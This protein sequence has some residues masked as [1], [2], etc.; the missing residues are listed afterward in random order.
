MDRLNLLHNKWV[1]TNLGVFTINNIDGDY[2][3]HPIDYFNFI[4]IPFISLLRYKYSGSGYV[5]GKED[6]FMQ[7]ITAKKKGVKKKIKHLLI[8]SASENQEKLGT[9]I[10]QKNTIDS[11]C[12]TCSALSIYTNSISAVPGGRGYRP[13]IGGGSQFMIY[14]WYGINETVVRLNNYNGLIQQPHV[15]WLADDDIGTCSICGNRGIVFHSFFLYNDSNID[16]SKKNDLQLKDEH[17][18]IINN[19]VTDFY[20][21]F[22]IHQKYKNNSKFMVNQIVNKKAKRFFLRTGLHVKNEFYAKH[23]YNLNFIFYKILND[24]NIAR[25]STEDLM[26]EKTFISLLDNSNN[27][28]L[29]AIRDL[30]AY[31][32]NKSLPSEHGFYVKSHMHIK[33]IFKKLDWS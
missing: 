6:R 8:T 21:D 32:M 25:N 5:S 33:N 28:V 4:I 16:Y 15:V 22:I 2:F 19:K 13:S 7:N 27:D 29:H 11:L 1:K 20:L 31:L 23:G 3:T 12:E 24:L 30:Y 10:I 26:M 18:N 9:N 17:S 14:P